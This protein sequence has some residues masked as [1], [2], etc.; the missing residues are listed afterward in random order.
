MNAS[1]HNASQGLGRMRHFASPACLA[2][3]LSADISGKMPRVPDPLWIRIALGVLLLAFAAR[4]WRALHLERALRRPIAGVPPMLARLW[5][6]Q[7]PRKATASPETAEQAAPDLSSIDVLFHLSRLD[8]RQM[9]RFHPRTPPASFEQLLGQFEA[10]TSAG[11]EDPALGER[12]LAQQLSYDAHDVLLETSQSTG[13]DAAPGC[14]ALVD[15]LRVRLVASPDKDAIDRCLERVPEVMVVTVADHAAAFA[16]NA[17]VV[18]LAEITHAEIAQASA[19]G[20]RPSADE[21]PAEAGRE[22]ARIER[23]GADRAAREEPAADQTGTSLTEIGS[24]IASQAVPPALYTAFRTAQLAAKGD[25][26]WLAHAKGE[27]VDTAASSVGGWAGGAMLGAVLGPVGM[28]AGGLIGGILGSKFAANMT[29][30]SREKRLR[31]LLAEQQML[32]AKVPRLGMETLAAQAQHLEGVAG[33]FRRRA[34]GF[35]VWPSTQRVANELIAAEYRRWQRRVTK[36]ERQLQAWLKSKPA[37]EKRAARGAKLLGERDLPW[38]VPWLELRW[39]LIQLGPKIEAER[40][41]LA[42]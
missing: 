23:P 25:G 32:L 38:S 3:R 6:Y 14:G 28:I 34:S 21:L 24:L 31:Q 42:K 16:D 37:E 5:V 26:Q 13:D 27:L 41:R 4:W 33:E 1:A 40:K 15:G 2:Q 20:A 12:L 17:K 36:Q 35:Y 10:V 11:P 8:R 18:A 19:A 9:A 39:Q 7:D 30:N 22:L 29:T